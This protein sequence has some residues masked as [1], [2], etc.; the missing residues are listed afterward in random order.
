MTGPI[1]NE[2]I[3]DKV[4]D[5]ALLLAAGFNHRQDTFDKAAAAIRLSPM[6]VASPEYGMTLGAFGAVVGRL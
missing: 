3:A 5:R 2:G 4:K 1:S 6:R